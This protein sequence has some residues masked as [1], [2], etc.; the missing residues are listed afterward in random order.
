VRVSLPWLEEAAR[1]RGGAIIRTALMLSFLRGV[2]RSA[3]VRPSA[4]RLRQF[5]LDRKA[6]FRGL[7]ALVRRG[8]VRVHHRPGGYPDVEILNVPAE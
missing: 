7:A 2:T 6:S 8:L 4:K 5:G 1:S 3:T